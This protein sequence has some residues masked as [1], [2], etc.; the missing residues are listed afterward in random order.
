MEMKLLGPLSGRG[1]MIGKNGADGVSCHE[2]V[3][4]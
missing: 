3:Q 1:G 4:R 2:L